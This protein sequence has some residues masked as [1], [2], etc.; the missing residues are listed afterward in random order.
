M[1]SM[2]LWPRPARKKLFARVELW[3]QEGG[4]RE[5][6]RLPKRQIAALPR[7]IWF[8]GCSS[9]RPVM[10]LGRIS[11]LILRSPST[12][13]SLRAGSGL[14]CVSRLQTQ[15]LGLSRRATRSARRLPAWARRW[16][17]GSS[18]RATSSLRA[19]LEPRCTP[20]AYQHQARQDPYGYAAQGHQLSALP[21]YL[22]WHFPRAQGCFPE[23]P[24]RWPIQ[25]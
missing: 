4:G 14:L 19:R 22:Y 2:H 11:Q 17:D 13:C 8:W 18:Y 10:T 23:S 5:F 3:G 9:D 20:L 15:L 21:P 1:I 16:T 12:R 7:S 6:V 24:L 25:N